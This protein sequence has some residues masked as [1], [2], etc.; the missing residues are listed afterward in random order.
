M[1]ARRVVLACAVSFAMM[2]A[3][4]ALAHAGSYDTSAIPNPDG[5]ISVQWAYAELAGYPSGH[6][7]WVGYDVLRRT[8]GDCASTFQRVNDTIFP[9]IMGQDQSYTFLDTPPG[10]GIEYEY[11]V[12]QVD[13]DRNRLFLGFPEC[14]LCDGQAFAGMPAF[15]APITQGTLSDATWT[16]RL[17]PCVTGCW[18][19]FYLDPSSTQLLRPYADGSTVLRFYGSSACDRFEGCSLHVDHFEVVTCDAVPTVRTSWG[20]LKA[21]YR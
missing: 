21:I 12:I 17:Q 8:T 6:P 20:R 16:L 13:V 9:R 18:T 4:V 5:T 19:P 10:G 3:T 2:A 14:D 1:N 11:D 15:A 7:E